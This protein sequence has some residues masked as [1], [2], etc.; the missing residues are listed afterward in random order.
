MK[1]TF[2]LKLLKIASLLLLIFIIFI[3][4]KQNFFNLYEG[5]ETLTEKQK[6]LQAIAE[7]FTGD[8]RNRLKSIIKKKSEQANAITQTLINE[9][10]E[11]TKIID[12]GIS[13]SVDNEEQK[14]ASLKNKFETIISNYEMTIKEN[15]QKGVT[16]DFGN[17]TEKKIRG[18]I[19]NY[20]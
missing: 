14:I 10:N 11:A 12:D 18:I 16:R 4:L 19:N 2:Y 7:K 9:F 1:S 5:A 8:L 13:N 20:I 6:E 3:V 17:L 15:V